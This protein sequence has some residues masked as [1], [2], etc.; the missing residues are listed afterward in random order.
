MTSIDRNSITLC[1]VDLLRILYLRVTLGQRLLDLCLLFRCGGE[2]KLKLHT[3]R[4]VSRCP[5]A[6]ESSTFLHGS[7]FRLD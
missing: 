3:G 4:N 5:P 6:A 2:A 7:Y 1:H